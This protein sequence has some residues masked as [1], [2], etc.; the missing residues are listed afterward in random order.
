MT[1][2]RGFLCTLGQHVT[3]AYMFVA[4]TACATK[5]AP[6]PPRADLIALVEPKPKPTAVILTDP[7][8]SDRY[9]SAVESWGERLSSA[10]LRLCRYFAATG[11]DVDCPKP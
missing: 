5:P 4:L 8:A 11:M 2:K 6:M 1:R 10:G 9:N 3:I 7:A